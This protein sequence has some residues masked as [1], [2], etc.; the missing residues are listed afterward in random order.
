M[1]AFWSGTG[2]VDDGGHGPVPT[3]GDPTA[4]EL[5]RAALEACDGGPF[6]AGVE[7]S[8]VFKDPATFDAAEPKRVDQSHGPGYLRDA[9]GFALEKP[10]QRDIL[11][12]CRTVWPMTAP[13]DVLRKLGA[14]GATYEPWL[15]SVTG[16]P[17][18]ATMKTWPQLGF[19]VRDTSGAD[20]IYVKQECVKPHKTETPS[21][22]RDRL[23]KAID[24]VIHIV[25]PSPVDLGR[26]FRELGRPGEVEDNRDDLSRLLHDVDRLDAGRLR[27]ELVGLRS[28]IARLKA[29]SRLV[30]G[31]LKK[32]KKKTTPKKKG[33][34][35]GKKA[36][37]RKS[38][39]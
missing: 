26:F 29:A 33:A 3:A 12:A 5:D 1:Q 7:V 15:N 28:K 36:A 2:F 34:A 39:H 4:D 17:D 9:A 16:V 13:L 6:K 14:G 37:P 24:D 18:Q 19:V 11:F 30:E 23:F 20:E 32:K 21:H 25:D 27:V 38:G 31:K 35:R 8:G 10:W 22:L